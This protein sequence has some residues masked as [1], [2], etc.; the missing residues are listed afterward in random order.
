MIKDQFVEK[1]K[2]QNLRTRLL[3][4]PPEEL[5]ELISVARALDEA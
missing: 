1:C 3:R 4:D 2:A 5:E